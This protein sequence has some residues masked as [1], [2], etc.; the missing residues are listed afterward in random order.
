MFVPTLCQ[1]CLLCLRLAPATVL[2]KTSRKSTYFFF[3]WKI[4][5]PL[6]RRLS[7]FKL[8]AKVHAQNGRL[9]LLP[10][11]IRCILLIHQSAGVRDFT[12][13]FFLFRLEASTTPSPN[14]TFEKTLTI[15]AFSMYVVLQAPGCASCFNVNGRL[16][17]KMLMPLAAGW[18]VLPPSQYLQ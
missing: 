13:T 4:F 1:N 5:H 9:R 6:K 17:C 12:Q 3:Q 10:Y 16:S 8:R 14:V 7:L 15:F 11:A 2:R 18:L